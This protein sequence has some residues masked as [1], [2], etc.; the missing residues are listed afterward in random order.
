MKNRAGRVQR[1]TDQPKA[2]SV[3]GG[4][5]ERRAQDVKLVGDA[6]VF[7]CD[8][9]RQDEIDRAYRV[10]ADAV[11]LAHDPARAVSPSSAQ[12]ARADAAVCRPPLAG[13]R[14]AGSTA[15]SAS[16]RDR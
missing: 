6:P 7:V 15:R 2:I 14:D 10:F 12:N 16:S 5:D 11:G 1:A 4:L 9:A 8:V 3:R 13:L